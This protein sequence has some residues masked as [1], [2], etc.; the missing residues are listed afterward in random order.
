M[1]HQ[2][3]ARLALVVDLMPTEDCPR[4]PDNDDRQTKVLGHATPRLAVPIGTADAALRVR[5]ALRRWIARR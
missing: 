4:L 1:Q 5:I 3:R 2:T